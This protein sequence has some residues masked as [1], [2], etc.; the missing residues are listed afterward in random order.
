MLQIVWI[1]RKLI[2]YFNKNIVGSLF[3]PFTIQKK[4][5]GKIFKTSIKFFLVLQSMEKTTAEKIKN[6]PYMF[7]NKKA[8]C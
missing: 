5:L 2:E 3:S 6:N 8:F 1:F 4:P 7:N